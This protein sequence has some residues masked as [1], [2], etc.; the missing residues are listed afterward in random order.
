MQVAVI[1]EKLKTAVDKIHVIDEILQIADK[2]IT[3]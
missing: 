3:K 1:E 2:N